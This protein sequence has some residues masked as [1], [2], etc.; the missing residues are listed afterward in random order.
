M[1][2]RIGMGMGVGTGLGANCRDLLQ[3]DTADRGGR[4]LGA[5]FPR[6]I[7]QQTADICGEWG[8]GQGCCLLLLLFRCMWPEYRSPPAQWVRAV[9]G[10][11]ASAFPKQRGRKTLALPWVCARWTSRCTGCAPALIPGLIAYFGARILTL[12][13]FASKKQQARLGSMGAVRLGVC[14]REGKELMDHGG[15]FGI[16]PF[17]LLLTGAPPE[18]LPLPRWGAASGWGS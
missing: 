4:E 10:G 2:M 6:R 18:P 5:W 14:L 1:D 13:L 3:G 11:V 16:L 12:P 8:R 7:S 9:F 17:L 15:M